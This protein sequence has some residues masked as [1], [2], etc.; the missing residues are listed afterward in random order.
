MHIEKV[1]LAGLLCEQILCNYIDFEKH[2]LVPNF[3][4]ADRSEW[5]LADKV[6]LT[7]ILQ[8]LISNALKYATGNLDF[9]IE[10][11]DNKTKLIV[12]NSVMQE[13]INTDLIFEKFYQNDLS[14][15]KDGSGIGL[16]LCRCFIEKLGGSISAEYRDG[17]LVISVILI[18]PNS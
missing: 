8:N 17:K 7:R 13:D 1:D 4:E 12:S 15:G 10:K 2:G 5:V 9:Y 6:M 14:R 16:Y 3:P 11:A 18:S